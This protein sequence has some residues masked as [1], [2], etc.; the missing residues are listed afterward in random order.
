MNMNEIKVYF[1]MVIEENERLLIQYQFYQFKG[2]GNFGTR[3]YYSVSKKVLKEHSMRCLNFWKKLELLDSF[4][5]SLVSI[6]EV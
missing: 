3:I 2:S 1:A 6:E 5:I 4:Q